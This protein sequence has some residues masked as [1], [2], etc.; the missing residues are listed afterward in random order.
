MMSDRRVARRAVGRGL[1]ATVFALVTAGV[2]IQ[3]PASSAHALGAPPR[4]ARTWY[5]DCSAPTAGNG[6]M[7]HPFNALQ[8]VNQLMLG[9]SD[10]VLFRRGTA[11]TGMLE[12]QGNGAPGNPVP[13]NACPCTGPRP[14]DREGQGAG[15]RL[16]A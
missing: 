4:S 16:I 3:L 5:V 15:H 7:A 11:C 6:T 14:T 13:V 2:A 10:R 12:P 8:A 9:P 1:V